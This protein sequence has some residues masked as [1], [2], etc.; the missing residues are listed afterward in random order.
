MQWSPAL[1][2]GEGGIGGAGALASG[3]NLPSDDR[4]KRR[5][6]PLGASEVEVEQ[7]DAPDAPVADL[8]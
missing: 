3:V 6:M 7:F 4:I 8:V 2:A 5:V 1:A